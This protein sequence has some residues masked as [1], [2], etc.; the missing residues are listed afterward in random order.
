MHYKKAKQQTGA[1]E[2]P[3]SPPNADGTSLPPMML[4]PHV[5]AQQIPQFAQ[6]QDFNDIASLQLSLECYPKEEM[7]ADEN[8]SSFEV[9][10]V[11]QIPMTPKMA[12]YDDPSSTYQTGTC[13]GCGPGSAAATGATPPNQCASAM[14]TG[15]SE[16]NGNSLNASDFDVNLI[17]NLITLQNLEDLESLHGANIAHNIVCFCSHHSNGDES[18]SLRPHSHHLDD[19]SGSNGYSG[20]D[21]DNKCCLII[22]INSM[23]PI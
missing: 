1:A 18:C 19:A 15:A 10:S 6:L 13:T 20:T 2:S 16:V 3:S 5:I 7:C 17:D 8:Y 21:Q 23:K 11:F 9:D 4:D 22:D 14:P 12:N